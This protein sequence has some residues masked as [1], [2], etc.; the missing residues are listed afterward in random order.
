[1]FG[2]FA[3]RSRNIFSY[4]DGVKKRAIDPAVAWRKMWENEDCKPQRDFGPATGIGQDGS[5]VEFE[6]A[7]QERVLRM[8]REMF[9]VQAWTEETPGLT[10][11]E[12]FALLWS[13]LGYMDQ[14]KKKRAPLPTTSPPT[15]SNSTSPVEDSTT[16]LASDSCS[17]GSESKSDEPSSSSKRSYQL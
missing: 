14:L 8:A 6:A 7:A 3:N 12:T 1:M 9:G 15:A 10:I 16:R 4:W 2:W 13:F 17:T 11:D 5:P